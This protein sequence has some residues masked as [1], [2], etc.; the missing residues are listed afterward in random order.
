MAQGIIRSLGAL[1][2]SVVLLGQPLHA[3]QKVEDLAFARADA[4]LALVDQD[5]YAESWDEA[6]QLFKAAITKEKWRETLAAVR[7]PLGKVLSRKVMSRQYTESLPGA[8]DGKYV[9]IQYQTSFERKK[10]AVETVT[11]MVDPDGTW[12]VSGYYIR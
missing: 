1:A 2:A 3:D 4:W 7:T 5:R 6:A 10:S 12:R 11:P 8:P 9:V